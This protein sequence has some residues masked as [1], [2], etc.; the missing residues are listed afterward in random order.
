DYLQ[1]HAYGNADTN[2][3]WV[4][5][6]KIA[7]QPVPELM[8][9]WIFQPGFPLVTAMISPSSELT[10]KQQR[11]SYRSDG[12]SRPTQDQRWQIPLQMRITTAGKTNTSRTLLTEKETTVPLP[13]NWESILLNEGGHGF[14]RVRYAPDLLGRLLNAGIDR[15]AVTERFNLINDAW[16]T[17][18]AG[19]MPLT[20][21]LELT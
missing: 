16:A 1:G 9:G 20:E 21:Y 13:H 12:E 3:L 6:G 7:K 8:N 4:S 2:D 10:I 17:T 15:L 14:Y 19:L 5:L 11:F 18:I